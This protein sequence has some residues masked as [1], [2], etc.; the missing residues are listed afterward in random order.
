[1]ELNEKLASKTLSEL[2]TLKECSALI[3]GKYGEMLSTYAQTQKDIYFKD[4]SRTEEVYY[5]N[6][7][8][9]KKLDSAIEVA[10]E[11]KLNE[12]IEDNTKVK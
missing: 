2:I 6:F 4:I 5:N 11:N 12:L 7:N 8:K 3:S 9:F 1:M 10:I